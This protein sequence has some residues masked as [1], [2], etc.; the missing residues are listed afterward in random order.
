MLSIPQGNILYAWLLA[1]RPKTLWASVAP[2][3][4]GSVCAYTDGAFEPYLFAA[5]LVCAVLIQI[6]SNLANDVFDF[7]RGADAR[8]RVGPLRVTQ[9]GLISA[10]RMK[11]A[12]ALVLVSALAI[13]VY[14]VSIG[15]WPILII[16]SLSLLFS[17]LYTAGPFPLA[18]MGLGEIFVL[19]F[20]GPL[21]VGGTFYLFASR[22]NTL[23]LGAG[24]CCG[25]I[26]SAILVVNNLR[27]IESDRSCGKLTLA[28][29]FGARFA[30][31]EYITLLVLAA[32][33]PLLLCFF[34]SWPARILL[35]SLFIFA[36]IPLMRAVY[37]EVEGPLLN[38]VLSGTAR[39]LLVFSGLFAIACLP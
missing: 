13:G 4:L 30:R 17:V 34:Y 11:F 6:A 23:A 26:S 24:L 22:I 38:E 31:W 25:L 39:L 15:G 2:V 33:I 7:E 8:N 19:L 1:T 28:A 16:G 36:A 14:L 37:L 9:A 35:S 27:D 12:L 29:R 18:Y 32:L 20:F 5:I 21:A 3:I 10:K